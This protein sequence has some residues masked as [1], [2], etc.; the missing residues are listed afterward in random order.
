MGQRKADSKVVYDYDFLVQTFPKAVGD[1]RLLDNL[2]EKRVATTLIETNENSS[3]R[4]ESRFESGNLRRGIRTAAREYDL[5]ICPDV[6]SS[7][8]QQWFY[9]EVSNM[10]AGE[11]YTFN[12]INNEK[13]SCE[14]QECGRCC[15][16]VKEAVRGRPHWVRVGTDVFYYR[17]AYRRP[18]RHP[19]KRQQGKQRVY[20][21]ASF[22]VTFPHTGDVC[23]L[24]FHYPYTYTRLQTML[25]LLEGAVE[26][27]V[28]WRNEPLAAD[29]D[30][31]PDPLVTVTG[32][33]LQHKKEVVFLTARIHPGESGAS[34]AMEGTLRFLLSAAPEAEALR[35]RFIFKLVPMLNVA[36]VVN[37]CHRCGLTDED[38][39][40]RWKT[41]DPLL[42]PVIYRAKTL[43]EYSTF[44]LKRVPYLFCDYHG[45]SCRKNIFLYG[46][47]NRRSWLPADRQRPDNDALVSCLPQALYRVAPAF[48]LRCCHLTVE[49][50]RETTAR[51]VVWRELGV[52]RSYTMESS[53]CGCDQGPYQ[54]CHLSTQQLQET[55]ARLA[56][57][58][59]LVS[60]PGD[61]AALERA[62]STYWW[63]PQE[64][65]EREFAMSSATNSDVTESDDDTDDVTSST[66]TSLT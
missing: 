7:R 28:W 51:V 52:Q 15:S 42:H 64:D 23:Y 13:L 16:R 17:N 6:G 2:D 40:R 63:R 35:D 50:S 5:V 9:F 39:N 37:G 30:G 36:G 33:T 54:G 25:E 26:P 27:E 1:V 47:S 57:A 31:N 60:V 55:G 3:L 22:T 44:V 62:R 49:R 8:H 38:L 65:F 43:M 66:V 10:L 21:T 24:A 12:L 20:C 58:L 4:F 45:H 61:L 18:A 53:Y 32:Q 41:P 59:H 19:S 11:P 56:V 46:C 14:Y 29:L 34:W 48:S